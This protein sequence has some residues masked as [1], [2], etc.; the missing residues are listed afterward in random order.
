MSDHACRLN[1]APGLDQRSRVVPD[2][3]VGSSDK[4]DESRLCRDPGSTPTA[5]SR[6]FVATMSQSACVPATVLNPPGFSRKGRS[7]SPP[8]LGGSFGVT[9]SPVPCERG[10]IGLTLPLCRTPPGQ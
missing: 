3:D 4:R 6:S 1:L 8:R 2:H 7:L 5:S 10:L 9:L